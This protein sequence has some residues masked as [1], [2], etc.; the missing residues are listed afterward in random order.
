MATLS[1][2]HQSDWKT[3]GYVKIPGF[4]SA[5]EVTDLQNWVAEIADWHPT[6]DRWMHHYE[7]TPE[8]A[9]LS[10]SENFVP[11]HPEMRATVTAGKV[12][13]AVSTLLGEQAVLYKE[14]I[15]YKYPGGGG[16]AAHQDAPAYAFVDFHITCLIS[17]DAATPE[18]GCLAFAPGRH[19]EG[20]IALDKN[21]CIAPETA[22]RMEWVPVP[23]APGD[24]LLFGSYIPHSSPA[25]R[26]DEPR[27]I[28][29]LT[30]N[31][32]SEG[33]WREKYYADKRQAFLAYAADGSNREKQISKIA[34]FQGASIDHEQLH[35]SDARGG[36][37][38][39]DPSTTG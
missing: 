37:D 11:Y 17:V 27:R 30:Y 9:R 15:N 35:R 19:R 16:Y 24:I 10:R 5:A 8:G 3:R 33:D 2:Q 31:A 13:A 1:P 7:A 25:N 38:R 34:H 22:A 20:F 6:P 36:D 4:F 21:G 23:T 28:L 18:S 39:S 29:Y 12:L 26:S 32:A 14:K